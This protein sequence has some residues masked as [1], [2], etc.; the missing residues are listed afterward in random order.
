MLTKTQLLVFYEICNGNDRL[1]KIQ[2]VLKKNNT[3]ISKIIGVLIK[4]KLI[5]KN[6][7]TLSVSE[8]FHALK[9]KELLLKSKHLIEVLHDSGL[10]I[11]ITLLEKK[12]LKELLK[13]T[14]LKEITIR[15]FIKNAQ[16]MSLLLKENKYYIVN[17][18]VWKNLIVFL[19]EYKKFQENY[20]PRIPLESKIYFKTKKE[21]VFSTEQELDA[22]LTSFSA[23]KD[24]DL[25]IYTFENF[26]YLPNK[27]LTK[28]DLLLHT[29]AIVEKTKEFRQRMYLALF[30]Y[31]YKKEFKDIKHEILDN[32][33]KIF[34]GE[35]I[36]T[37]PPLKEIKEKAE[38]YNI[39]M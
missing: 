32:L 18:K 9:L 12:T 29:L 37:Y 22:T 19:E 4:E 28:K 13:E 3:H 35:K 21:I 30:Y 36:E 1:N 17:Y 16:T 8:Q 11:L 25:L 26:Y 39:K 38:L 6:K 34:S 5:V 31:K 2:N 7:Q 33:N 15:K 14:H 27:K 10:L 23:F 20:D 24:Y